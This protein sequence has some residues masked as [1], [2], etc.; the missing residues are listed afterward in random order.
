MKNTF[1]LDLATITGITGIRQEVLKFAQWMEK[2]L[3]E[4]DHKGGWETMETDWLI[5]RIDEELCELRRKVKEEAP[6]RHIAR[7]CADIANFAMMIADNHS[8]GQNH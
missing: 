3:Q 2:K 6:N 1:E 7:E 5:G 8:M 4:N